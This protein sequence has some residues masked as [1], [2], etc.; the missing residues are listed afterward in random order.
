MFPAELMAVFTNLLSNAV[1][2]AGE[3]GRILATALES[4]QGEFLLRPGQK[5]YVDRYQA[6]TDSQQR[7]V[8]LKWNVEI[9]KYLF[10]RFSPSNVVCTQP[11]YIGRLAMMANPNPSNKTFT[12]HMHTLIILH[13]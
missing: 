11:F 3:G 2:A 1:K 9:R 5:G 13:P 10:S 7:V 12:R 8:H 4:E 6:H